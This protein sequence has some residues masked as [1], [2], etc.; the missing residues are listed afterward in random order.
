MRSALTPLPCAPSAY[1]PYTQQWCMSPLPVSCSSTPGCHVPLPF[2]LSQV[3]RA[4]PSLCMTEVRS[5]LQ[6]CSRAPCSSLP[7]KCPGDAGYA[8]LLAPHQGSQHRGVRS[9]AELGARC[10]ARQG[11]VALGLI[12]LLQASFSCSAM[13]EPHSSLTHC[14][15][16]QPSS[17]RPHPASLRAVLLM[18]PVYFHG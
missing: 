3:P 2:Y 15:A 1:S 5:S 11:N 13:K 14:V 17:P 7:A 16:S 18:I 12:L 4:L 10:P 8:L 6:F 9:V